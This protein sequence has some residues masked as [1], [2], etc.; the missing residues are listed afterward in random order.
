MRAHCHGGDGDDGHTIGI[1][2]SRLLRRRKSRGYSSPSIQQHEMKMT[3]VQATL[4]PYAIAC[5]VE[6]PCFF[7][8]TPLPK[9]G[10]VIKV[11]LVKVY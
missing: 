1:L 4:C 3:A 11:R 10:K 2:V 8:R 6:S 5:S 7:C 9:N